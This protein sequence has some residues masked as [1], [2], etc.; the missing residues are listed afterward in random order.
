HVARFAAG[1]SRLAGR[2]LQLL[3]RFIG[4]G[5]GDRLAA[6]IDLHVRGGRALLHL[7]DPSFEPVAST[8]LHVTSPRGGGVTPPVHWHWG[9]TIP[10]R[11]SCNPRSPSGPRARRA[12]R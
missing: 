11:S 9:R 12:S 7:D 3:D 1:V 8:D 2:E 10:A 4:D 6:D 5:S